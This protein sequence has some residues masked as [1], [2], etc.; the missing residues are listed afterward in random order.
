MKKLF[1]GLF[2][3]S[4]H[5]INFECNEEIEE[6]VIQKTSMN[7]KNYFKNNTL[8]NKHE[9]HF[10][11]TTG[12]NE[13]YLFSKEREFPIGGK[14]YEK[15]FPQLLKIFL[16]NTPKNVNVKIVVDNLVYKDNAWLQSFKE[17]FKER[18]SYHDISKVSETII[19]KCNKEY[20]SLLKEVFEN[21]TNGN[22][23]IASDVYRIIGTVYGYDTFPTFPVVYSDVDVFCHSLKH[24]NYEKYLKALFPLDCPKNK[25]VV[26][27]RKK[28]SNDVVFNY[29]KNKH[30]FKEI[31]K[32]L[33][34][35]IQN[36]SKENKI[37]N[38]F[39]NLYSYYNN[40]EDEANFNKCL[41]WLDIS[42]IDD[43]KISIISATG[44]GLLD[45]VYR[46]F[47]KDGSFFYLDNYPPIYALEWLGDASFLITS[48]NHTLISH[49]DLYKN[50]F[51]IYEKRLNSY[52]FT[53]FIFSLLK[54]IGGNES[55]NVKI[56]KYLSN[57][58]PYFD[59]SFKVLLNKA[60]T[61]CDDKNIMGKKEFLKN[62]IDEKKLYYENVI[63]KYNKTKE[64]CPTGINVPVY[65]KIQYA[66][67]SHGID[68][69][70]DPENYDFNFNDNLN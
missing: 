35:E 2:L 69:E 49:D 52:K 55:F 9:V 47:H 50:E 28:N 13:K 21:A 46:K 62:A 70:I 39:S 27:G 42:Q 14:K 43:P 30:A 45:E 51:E 58:N 48:G 38:Y 24:E 18:L 4:F 56:N 63:L 31:E 66:L 5:L 67:K 33:L 1:F 6:N 61:K 64:S 19:K 60:F 37:L 54:K 20:E 8:E 34:K 59:K 29:A 16:E 57:K 36:Y 32:S 12:A 15:E 65:L 23:A 7:L 53:I 22:P 44:P 11:W 68:F 41:E 10:Y 25:K 3:L 26:F 40:V 17:Q